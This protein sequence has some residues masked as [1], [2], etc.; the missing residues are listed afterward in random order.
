MADIRVELQIPGGVTFIGTSIPDDMQTGQIIDEIISELVLPRVVDGREIKYSLLLVDS[1]RYLISGESLF[2]AGV[3]DGATL[4][5]VS[6]GESEIDVTPSLD[7]PSIS[8]S[9]PLT[10]A[11]T[12][13]IF[14]CHS[15]G[16][17]QA[18]RALYNRLRGDGFDPWLD[19]QNLVPGQV[20][21]REIIK[22]VR[23]SD[24]VLV[25]L[26]EKAISKAGYVQKEIKHALDVADEQPEGAIFLIP[27]RLEECDVPQRL[28]RWQWVN[29]FEDQGYRRLITA[30]EVKASQLSLHL[31]QDCE[32]SNKPET[33]R[34]SNDY[35]LEGFHGIEQLF[36][37]NRI[38]RW[39]PNH[40]WKAMKSAENK[41]P[42]VRLIISQEVLLK[43]HENVYQNS[44][45]EVGGFL[46]GNKYKCPKSNLNYVIVDQLQAATI[47]ETTESSFGSSRASWERLAEE[48]SGKFVGKLLLGWY[49]S[50]PRFG[51]FLSPHDIYLHQTYFNEPWMTALVIDP[52]KQHG[53][54]FCWRE[55]QVIS[56]LP[57]DFYE[58]VSISTRD[59]VVAWDNYSG[60]DISTTLPPPLQLLN[61]SSIQWNTPSRGG[62]R[63]VRTKAD[64]FRRSTS[65]RY[66]VLAKAYADLIN[67]TKRSKFI[68][69]HPVDVK[70]YHPP[71]KY[72]VT[73][74][75]RSIAGVTQEGIPIA[76]DFH[77][78]S[79]YLADGYPK[80]EPHLKW[81][82]PI[83][84][85]NIEHKEPHYVSWSGALGEGWNKSLG[86]LVLKLGEMIQYKRYH[87]EWS[88]PWPLD[89][90]V[91]KWVR[92]YAEPKGLLNKDKPFDERSLI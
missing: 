56:R 13:R 69:F 9:Q 72:I 63:N 71:E 48:L 15:S 47:A 81:I 45:M 91:A 16:D 7:S 74:T 62:E 44:E 29:F 58:L 2:S 68:H 55:G 17:K 49:H 11:Q 89:E 73:F 20:W 41:P 39:T 14:L 46:L 37:S 35:D 78:V 5:L 34:A 59:T 32:P 22:A 86:D 50:H 65:N 90:E 57:V 52:E 38:I 30:L 61:T 53:G 19:E 10:S 28:S 4:R 83:W 66:E 67:L 79:I 23:E 33:E 82:T 77:Q 36:P 24:V 42:E 40:T 87:A 27:V 21:D 51:V 12:L 6:S 88:S 18:V 26:S 80:Q 92:E 84:H 8:A 3:H 25:C 75:C 54:F 76:S 43:V 85:P 31:G 1:D 60:V 70:P 64:K